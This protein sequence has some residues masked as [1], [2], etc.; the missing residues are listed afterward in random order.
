MLQM[1]GRDCAPR[2]DCVRVVGLEMDR[3]DVIDLIRVGMESSL[4]LAC[5]SRAIVEIRLAMLEMCPSNVT[6]YIMSL[7]FLLSLWARMVIFISGRSICEEEGMY[8]SIS[9]VN[10]PSRMSNGATA[11]AKNEETIADPLRLPVAAVEDIWK[12]PSIISVRRI[13]D[14]LH[15]EL[16][17]AI[18]ERE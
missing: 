15:P 9:R 7:M 1:K 17:R 10:Y 14:L 5:R 13:D 18:E 6:T 2:F 8:I 11:E 3:G 12:A 16:K 4:V